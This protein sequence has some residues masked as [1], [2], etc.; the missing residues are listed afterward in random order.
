MSREIYRAPWHDYQS[1]CIYMVTMNKA[2]GVRD[3]G[4]LAG[5]VKIPRGNPGSPFVS[6]SPTGDA[7]KS[8]LRKFHEIEPAAR[9]Y[10]YAIMP[11]HLH[12]LLHI[13][14]RTEATL[15]MTIAR[16]KTAVNDFAG[17]THVFDKGF[18]DQILKPDRSLQTL[19][20]YIR[21]NPRRLAERRANPDF[22]RRLN[23]LTIAGHPCQAYGNLQLIDNPFKQQVIVHR[24]DT[25][26]QRDFNRLNWLYTADNG[27]V[28]VSP[29]ISPDERAIRDEADAIN[30]RFILLTSETFGE[31]YKPSGH[32][33]E[34]CES[35]RLL[36]I[37][38]PPARTT[39][40]SQPSQSGAIT[41]NTC[42]ALNALAAAI[43]N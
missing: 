22:F 19:Y 35:G 13:Q 24:A 29:F 15:G 2:P 14:Y 38:C 37:S 9:I 12:L 18:N 41:R 25:R 17:I 34:L 23:N 21:D 3:F 6:T 20:D 36:I 10:Q 16:F 30:G 40:G 39:G 43:A 26:Q 28:L 5:D 27:G 4:S 7:I 8:A 1:P 42:L 11:D 31:R 33:F 32:N